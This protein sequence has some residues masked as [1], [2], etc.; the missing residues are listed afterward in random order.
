MQPDEVPLLEFESGF[1]RIVRPLLA[2]SAR[3]PVFRAM[4]N[5]NYLADRGKNDFLGTAYIAVGAICI[6]LAL[7][8]SK[9]M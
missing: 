9:V 1:K 2:I 6:A 7:V 8:R 3:A 5:L 4:G